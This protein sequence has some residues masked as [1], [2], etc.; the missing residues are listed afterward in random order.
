M[1]SAKVF[2]ISIAA[3]LIVGSGGGVALDIMAIFALAG[4][5]IMA[6]VAALLR[7]SAAQVE[8]GN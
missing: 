6:L 5:A 1:P 4:V 8:A 2:G 3:G 7:R